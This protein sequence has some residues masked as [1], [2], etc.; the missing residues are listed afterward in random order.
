MK[1]S[2]KSLIVFLALFSL[3]SF[4]FMGLETR[5]AEVPSE[6][7]DQSGKTATTTIA[8]APA[9]AA[10]PFAFADFTWLNGNSRQKSPVFDT[11]YFTAEFT[12]DVNYLYD[13]NH[14]RDHSITGSTT[15]GRTSELQIA[16]L[17]IGGDFHDGHAR[18]RL[19]TQFGTYST[20]NPRNDAST[21]RGQWNLG[22]AYRYI[23]EGYAGYHWDI[24][25]GVNL[26]AG[27]FLSY[28]GLCSYYNFENWVY[29]MSYVSA[30]TPWYF[31]GLRLQM[32][33][34]DHFKAELWLV[35][36]WQSYGQFNE[37]PGV[38]FE[39]LWRPT[40]DYSYVTNW[41]YGHD[42]LGVP[43]RMRFHTDTSAQVKYLDHQNS[44]LDKAAFSVT[45]DA[46]CENGD[47]VQCLGSSAGKSAQN[48]FGFM[49]YN[50][51]W[52]AKDKYALTLGGGA[53]TNPGRYLVVTPPING[54]TAYTG[55]SYFTQNPGDSYR[56]WDGSLTFNYMPSESVTFLVELDH[57]QT[58]VPYFSGQGGVTPGAT[59]QGAPGSTV[60]GWQPDLT[61]FENRINTAMM[62]RF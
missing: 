51:F 37:A 39:L 53:V 49:V 6:S 35:N 21:S 26:D 41:Y 45:V 33:P 48:F 20:T 17:G 59:N 27:Q 15:S 16:Q 32:F 55:S 56:A 28:V 24:W 8:A 5:A 54:A 31:N 2:R 46:G 22:D 25:N 38:G 44:V 13:F 10:D 50:R 34:T 9:A 7:A 62:V 57:R 58:N 47:Q 40:G 19:M 1:S 4:S 11:K 23:S 14:P 12:F 60:A 42:T 52:F 3:P 30:N 43:N 36:G 61:K 18:G 29:Q